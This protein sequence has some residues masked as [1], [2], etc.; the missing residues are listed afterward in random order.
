[1]CLHHTMYPRYPRDSWETEALIQT[2][3]AV[4]KVVIGVNEAIEP[5]M[6]YAFSSS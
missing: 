2:Q 5:F 4:R 1:M 3:T 6:Y